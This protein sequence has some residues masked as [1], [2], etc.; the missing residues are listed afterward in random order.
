MNT[1]TFAVALQGLD[2]FAVKPTLLV[3]TSQTVVGE[4]LVYLAKATPVLTAAV[5]TLMPGEATGWHT[6]AAPAF[7]YV[8]EGTLTVDYG[9]H[10][11]QS[12]GPGDAIVEAMAIAHNG[13]NDGDVPMRILAVFMG[14]EGVPNTT[15]RDA[16]QV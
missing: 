9:P 3:S 12:Y 16:P 2:K 8:L 13:Y 15:P 10:G 11:V 7:G 1:T 5:V 4:P 14:A 6:H